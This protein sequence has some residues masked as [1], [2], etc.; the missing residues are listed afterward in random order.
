MV[1]DDPDD[2]LLLERAIRRIDGARA[3]LELEVESAADGAEALAILRDRPHQFDVLI[4]D[5]NMP[6]MGGLELLRAVKSESATADLAVILV[7][8]AAAREEII[9]GIAAG[10]YHYLAKP[11]DGDVLAAMVTATLTE[12]ERTRELHQQIAVGVLAA[13]LMESGSFRFRTPEEATQLGAFLATA[14][15]DPGRVV[16]GLTEL[17][18]NAVEHG[19]LEISYQEKGRLNL[20]GRWRQEVEA[21]LADP[22]FAR[23]RA[24]VA[25]RRGEDGVAVTITDQGP[26][27][28]PTPFLVFD[29]ARAFDNHGRGIALARALSFDDLEYRDGGRTVIAT[30]RG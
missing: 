12:A 30:V 25:V 29:P 2:R 21:R 27:F 18:V 22:A 13:E 11:V 9:E 15:P 1:D 28:D 19:N 5:R 20:D 14:F 23:R 16:T 3:G 4:S 8:A 6:R 24:E 26:G 7:T 10:A 17:L